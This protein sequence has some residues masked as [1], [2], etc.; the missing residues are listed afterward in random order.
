MKNTIKWFGIVAF[1]A[2]IG[3]SLIACDDSDSDN[4][5]GNNTG[6]NNFVLTL[7]S[8]DASIFNNQTTNLWLRFN[9][10]E[11]NLI[12]VNNITL[13][14]VSGVQIIGLSKPTPGDDYY[15]AISVP[16]KT[17]GTLTVSVSRSGQAVNGSPKTVFVYNNN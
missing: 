17:S 5:G 3:F 10:K 8:V 6:G 9:S 11:S 7:N 13:S 4:T 15:L 14:G 2:I 16:S 1:F 12:S